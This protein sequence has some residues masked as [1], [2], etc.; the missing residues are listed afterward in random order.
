MLFNIR[1]K[2]IIICVGEFKCYCPWL[3][4]ADLKQKS[5]QSVHE[6]VQYISQKTNSNFGVNANSKNGSNIHKCSHM[7]LSRSD[8][9]CLLSF[10]CNYYK[11]IY[12]AG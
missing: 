12:K 4:I 2:V 5:P 3:D 6:F 9:G 11:Y 8:S 1:K 7:Y 10:S